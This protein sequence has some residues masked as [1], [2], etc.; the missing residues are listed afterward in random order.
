M[1]YWKPGLTG[2]TVGEYLANARIALS[3]VHLWLIY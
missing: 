1:I 3:L 2:H